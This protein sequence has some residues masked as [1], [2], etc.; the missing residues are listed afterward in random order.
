MPTVKVK[1][2]EKPVLLFDVINLKK[3]D[4]K[5]AETMAEVRTLLGIKQP[6]LNA[7]N[8]DEEEK[9]YKIGSGS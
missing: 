7:V 1:G 4:E 5:G 6:D 2:K 8:M 9:K 3:R